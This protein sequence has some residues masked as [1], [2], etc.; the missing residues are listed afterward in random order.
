MTRVLFVC[1]GNI[2]R[3]PMAE[4]LFKEHVKKAGLSGK[5]EVDSAGTGAWHIGEPPHEGTRKK[6]A[7]KGLGT[8]GMT[9]RQLTEEDFEAFQYIIAMDAENL[10]E[11]HKMAGYDSVAYTG[12]LLDFVSGNM[13][14]DVPDPFFTGN[15]DSVY[16]LIDEGCRHLLEFIRERE[17]L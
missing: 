11:I 10:G 4:V 13:V 14:D 1:L 2:C 9:G 6:L 15:F 3:S 16:G 5:V 17:N 8:E 12:R 7:E